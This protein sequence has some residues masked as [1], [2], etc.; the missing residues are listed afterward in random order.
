MVRTLSLGMAL[1]Q[2]RKSTCFHVKERWE[3][4]W[5][6]SK[7]L[8]LMIYVASHVTLKTSIFPPCFCK[9]MLLETALL[10][11]GYMALWDQE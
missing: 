4:K 1:A 6:P 11:R 3:V 10:G 9:E 7:G 8:F 5:E 2:L